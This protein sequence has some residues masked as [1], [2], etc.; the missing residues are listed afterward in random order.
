MSHPIY[1][2]GVGADGAA[3]LRPEQVERI[4]S[5]DFLAGGERHLGYFPQARGERFVLKDNLVGLLEALGKRY[6]EQRCVVLASGDPLFYGV[7]KHLTGILGRESVRVE[8][9]LSSMQLAFARAGWTWEGA[10]LTS[11]HGGRDVRASL[12]PL[13]GRPR[14]GLFTQ[15]GN[16]P[17]A[18]AR[19]FL[20]RGL[21][22]YEAVVGENLGSADER[23]T[24]WASLRE[25]AQ[26]SFGPLNYLALW[27]TGYPVPL[28]EEDHNR[29]LVPGIPD[30]VFA[31][32]ESAPEVMTRQ[33]VRSVILAKLLLPTRPGDVVW[34][35]GS[36]LG[37]VSVEVAVLRPDVEVVAVERDPERA[38][39]LRQNRE[40][41]GAY[42]IRIVE[43]SAPE[44]LAGETERPRL[45]FVGGSG[46]R[47]AQILDFVSE[48]LRAGGRLVV[49]L[50]TL[51]NLALALEHV[52]RLGWPFTVTEVHV[53]RSDPLA[54]LTG[55]KPQRGVFL[56]QADKPDHAQE[57]KTVP[58]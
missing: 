43:G 25:L 54:G 3:G 17:G 5:A 20:E 57:S 52:R 32:P 14:I 6:H 35:I 12:L 24:R 48:R 42:N 15:D 23:V 58:P 38:G 30:E 56:V 2:I 7:G 49:S 9:A 40:R 53:A 1:V 4:L 19:F 34:D 13:L 28:P 8:P 55:L 47:L 45:V 18:V 11:I 41:F 36:G 33:E 29:A 31:R 21:P 46:G 27:R 44:V 22:E 50:V 51:E 16:S 26:Q 39:Y 37:T 10:A